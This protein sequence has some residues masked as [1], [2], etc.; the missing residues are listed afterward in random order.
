MSERGESETVDTW[1]TCV[2]RR[3]DRVAAVSLEHLDNHTHQRGVS[4]SG[5]ATR[6][7][8]SSAAEG[9]DLSA[10]SAQGY[11]TKSS[12]G[13]ILT[14]YWPAVSADEPLLRTAVTINREELWLAR[15]ADASCAVV[16]KVG[17]TAESE[18][19][20]INAGAPVGLLWDNTSPPKR[21]M[22]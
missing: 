14:R 21:P 6:L 4:G 16:T 1:G 8:V 15:Q 18:R 11:S 2:S 7:G 9:K 12:W 3:R 10:E 17:A 5:K 19:V 20:G 22:V 13:S